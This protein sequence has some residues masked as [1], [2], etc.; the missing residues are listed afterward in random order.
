MTPAVVAEE[1]C[2][3]TQWCCGNKRRR[4]QLSGKRT[5]A[6]LWG[7]GDPAD[8]Q[9][10]RSNR[11]QVGAMNIDSALRLKSYLR[12]WE[13]A[14]EQS[15]LK[16]SNVGYCP[17]A[18]LPLSKSPGHIAASKRRQPFWS[19]RWLFS[20][21]CLKAFHY[22][23]KSTSLYL[24]RKARKQWDVLHQHLLC[25]ALPQTFAHISYFMLTTWGRRQYGLHVKVR[26]TEALPVWPRSHSTEKQ[27]QGPLEPSLNLFSSLIFL[28]WPFPALEVLTLPAFLEYTIHFTH[29]FIFALFPLAGI[30]LSLSVTWSGVCK[31]GVQWHTL[32]CPGQLQNLLGSC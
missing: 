14:Y 26:R 32:V 23:R 27:F 28:P 30:H 19:Q 15:L 8:L 7:H 18:V 31:D 6:K 20:L 5:E 25:A 22:R 13:V 4:N 12:S 24:G 11:A 21:W 16:V 2:A 10:L 3:R 1:E 9:S 17:P 29:L